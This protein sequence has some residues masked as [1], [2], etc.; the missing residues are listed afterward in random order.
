[1]SYTKGPWKYNAGFRS[2]DGSFAVTQDQEYD[3]T[4][5]GFVT[6]HGKAK[7]GQAWCT[8]DPEGEANARLIAAAPDYAKAAEELLN[9]TDYCDDKRPLMQALRAAHAHATGA[10]KGGK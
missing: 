4:H 10:E 1:M 3:P 2:N 5:I 7:R 8:P 9:S 6:F